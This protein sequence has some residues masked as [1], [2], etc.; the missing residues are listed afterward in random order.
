MV[1]DKVLKAWFSREIFPLEPALTRYIRSN[2]RDQGE[3]ADLRQEVY[4]RG[5]LPRFHG[6]LG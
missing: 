4:A 5:V 2:W 3:V 1:D 6:R